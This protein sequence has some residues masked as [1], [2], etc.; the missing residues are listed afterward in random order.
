MRRVAGGETGSVNA[1][2]RVIE[3]GRVSCNFGAN[4]GDSAPVAYLCAT[5]SKNGSPASIPVLK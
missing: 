1:G 3:S 2:E 4:K 5:S